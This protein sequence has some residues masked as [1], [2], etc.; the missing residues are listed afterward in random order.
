MYPL[1]NRLFQYSKVGLL[2]IS[3]NFNHVF[4]QTFS[5]DTFIDSAI[6]ANPDLIVLK[7]QT[8]YKT[9]EIEMIKAENKSPKMY[10]SADYLFAP[11][12]N[13]DD[14]VVTINPAHK[15]I[16]YDIGITNG[17]LYSALY[18]IEY[19]LFN[20][21]Q[22][23]IL[24]SEKENEIEK[25]NYQ[26]E[27]LKNELQFKITNLFY[28][29]FKSFI[30]YQY[31]IQNN[32]FL[33]RQLDVVKQLTEKGIFKYVDYKLMEIELHSNNLDLKKFESEY[34]SNL[35]A[36]RNDC[37]ISDS[38]LVQLE[39][40]DLLL[41]EDTLSHSLFLDSYKND[42]ISA[43]IQQN[44]F[45]SRYKPQVHVYGNTGLNA[46]TTN[47]I[48]RRFGLSAGLQLTY[49]FYDG[50]QK[51]I[52]RQQEQILIDQAS[53]LKALKSK[54]IIRQ[55]Q[56]LKNNIETA[57]TNLLSE[58]EII[59][60]YENLITICQTELQ[61]AEIPIIDFLNINRNF[62]EKKLNFALQR[63]DLNVLINNYNYWGQ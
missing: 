16:G 35:N 50:N 41:T 54:E 22:T 17:G 19:P 13:N 34:R 10:L 53:E 47:D 40:K 3:L 58:K 32:D 60:E 44:V 46:V 1:I 48:Q 12:F 62:F 25:I 42:S 24:I 36:L 63:V 23:S 20:Q 6:R 11:Y 8:R 4:T 43:T 49:T 33:N 52:N 56:T 18:N 57:R 31:A 38:S 61:Q 30:S 9:L 2:L 55:K 29:A 26:I 45:N 5:L 39:N 14:Q 21:K 37:G 27:I 15:A 51:S 59:S 7:N 28:E